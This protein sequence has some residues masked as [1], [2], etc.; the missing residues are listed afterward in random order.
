MAST[1][2]ASALSAVLRCRRNIW[3]SPSTRLTGSA[4][5]DSLPVKPVSFWEAFTRGERLVLGRLALTCTAPEKKPRAQKVCHTL[6]QSGHA[7]K[8][9]A[10]APDTRSSLTRARVVFVCEAS[11]GGGLKV[12]VC[13]RGLGTAERKCS[14]LWVSLRSS[15]VSLTSLLS[16]FMLDKLLVLFRPHTNQDKDESKSSKNE[17]QVN[18]GQTNSD[19]SSE[20]SSVPRTQITEDRPD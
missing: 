4:A 3:K 8:P 14:W 6:A 19:W 18:H 2:S 9:T 1:P 7:R 20:R 17:L 11:S 15:C 13:S 5:R 16:H 12:S 10:H